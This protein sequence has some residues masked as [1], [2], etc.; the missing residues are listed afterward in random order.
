MADYLQRSARHIA[1]RTDVEHAYEVGVAAVNYAKSGKNAIMPIIIRTQDNPYAW[2]VGETDLD[3]VANIEKTLPSD[4]ISDD[5]FS[6]TKDCIQYLQPLING[7]DYPPYVD[8]VPNYVSLKK[9]F[10]PRKLTDYFAI[11]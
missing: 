9:Q 3:K 11:E 4:F 6:V 2:A 5:G 1:S 7:E 8:G 10:A